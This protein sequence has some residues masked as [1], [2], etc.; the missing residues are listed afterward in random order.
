[1][2]APGRLTSIPTA[3]TIPFES[4]IIDSTNV[5][6]AI[7]EAAD[8]SLAW[9]YIPAGKVVRAPLNRTIFTY[10]NLTLEGS[11]EI[12]GEWVIL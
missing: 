11:L 8:S 2:T 5:Q 7:N 4:E 1:M 10:S 9:Y 12:E 6:D 3:E